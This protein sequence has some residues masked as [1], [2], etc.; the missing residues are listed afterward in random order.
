MLIKVTHAETGK[1]YTIPVT[2]FVVQNDGGESIAVGFESSGLIV[3]SD[4]T[5]A[6]FAQVL[7]TAGVK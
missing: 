2:Q 4:A 7:R 3:Y 1:S 5:Q 6:D